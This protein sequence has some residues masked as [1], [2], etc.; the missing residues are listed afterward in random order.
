MKGIFS[1]ENALK[2]TLPSSLVCRD[3]EENQFARNRITK[4]VQFSSCKNW[5][6]MVKLQIER[7]VRQVKV[8][9]AGGQVRL[10]G[11]NSKFKENT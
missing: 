3:F 6:R 4:L 5:L 7:N 11:Q 8:F 1:P 10:G 2:A 9:L